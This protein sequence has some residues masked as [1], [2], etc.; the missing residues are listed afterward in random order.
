MKGLSVRRAL[1][2]SA[3]ARIGSSVIGFASVMVLSRLLTPT[4]TGIFSVSAA[5]IT[6][7]HALRE[8]G[9]T[10]YINQERELTAE[11]VAT[12][13]GIAIAIGWSI[14]IAL[15]VIS[16]PAAQWYAQPGVG[17]TIRVLAIGFFIIPIGSPSIA[18]LY[19]DMRYRELTYI[20]LCSNVAS[21]L[22]A[23]GL[24]AAGASY[25][26]LAYAN[27][28][29]LVA[30]TIG[31]VVVRAPYLFA[32]P[33]FSEWRH[34]TR[35]G[36][37]ACASLIITYAGRIAPDLI[38][39]RFLG[40]APVAYL[41]RANGMTEIFRDTTVS[42]MQPVALSAFSAGHRDGANLKAGYLRAMAL[43][44]GIAWPFFA[45]LAISA[46]PVV[47]L[48]YGAQW[49]ESVPLLRVLCLG[50]ALTALSALA[51]PAL[52]AVGQPHRLMWREAVSQGSLIL[53]IVIA[54]QFS[55][56]LV[57]WALTVG[58]AVAF[59]SAQY[60]LA[61]V[62]ALRLD[63]VAHATLPS[64]ALTLISAGPAAA[65]LYWLDWQSY[66]AMA[67]TALIGACST[68]IW[69]LG[70]LITRHP[71]QGELANALRSAIV[72]AKSLWPRAKSN[73]AE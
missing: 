68:I 45:V 29:G 13:L 15:W 43:Y 36:F 18:M 67:V 54:S 66:G 24:A 47:R 12:T 65:I 32:R 46:S 21:S 55:L 20:N 14:A 70:V 40:I 31:L 26:S 64:A 25:M 30:T 73:A 37:Y 6:L 10:S 56:W 35:F 22:A 49:D 27:I 60:H 5:M 42:M 39:G 23:I 7:A 57:A 8:F 71:L 4:E 2:M 44:A 62:F 3:I 34:V 41:S 63:D 69:I 28:V 16:E 53:L 33:G 9:I 11:R 58:A 38:V 59:L 48:L 72:Q 52:N 51:G 1:A 17:A 61:A 50:G 19:R